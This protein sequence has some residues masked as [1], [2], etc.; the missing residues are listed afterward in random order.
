MNTLR[1]ILED[2]LYDNIV[3]PRFSPHIN[4]FRCNS[5]GDEE[6]AQLQESV[7]HTKL[8]CM[9]GEGITLRA[10]KGNPGEAPAP[11]DSWH[12]LSKE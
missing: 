5:L 7:A 12:F 3:D 8:G 11:L 10:R 2:G 4:I 6:K 1:E 9:V